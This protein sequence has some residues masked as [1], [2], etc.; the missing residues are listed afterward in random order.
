MPSSIPPV[1]SYVSASAAFA[2]ATSPRSFFGGVPSTDNT[3]QQ[4]VIPQEQLGSHFFEQQLQL[5]AQQQRVVVRMLAFCCII[6]P[7]YA[8]LV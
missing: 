7:H 4:P 1:S 3:Q 8:N 5:A 2:R 6:K